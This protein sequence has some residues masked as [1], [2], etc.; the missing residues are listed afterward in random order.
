VSPQGGRTEGVATTGTPPVRAPQAGG[1]S[2]ARHVTAPVSVTIFENGAGQLDVGPGGSRTVYDIHRDGGTWRAEHLQGPE[3]GYTSY[4]ADTV[5]NL[6]RKLA[7]AHGVSGT[8]SIEDERDKGKS[9]TQRFEHQNPIARR[10]QLTDEIRAGG[11][12]GA[13]QSSLSRTL[14]GKLAGVQTPPR[15]PEADAERLRFNT[16]PGEGMR[17][18]LAAQ[19]AASDANVAAVTIWDPETRKP[20]R[21]EQRP[22]KVTGLDRIKN[23]DHRRIAEQA[24]RAGQASYPAEYRAPNIEFTTDGVETMGA[25]W[26]QFGVRVGK[27]AV[28]IHP[29][30]V[31]HR[32]DRMP[33]MVRHELAHRAESILYSKVEAR[34]G[35]AAADAWKAD[36]DREALAWL[37][38]AREAAPDDSRLTYAR[39]TEDFH[40]KG[41][42]GGGIPEH[43]AFAEVVAYLKDG[44]ALPGDSSRLEAL[45]RRADPNFVG[46]SS[47]TGSAS[48]SG[49][50][51]PFNP[52]VA[53]GGGMVPRRDG[54][55]DTAYSLRT[56]PSDDAAKRL[57]EG[58]NA[59][60][61]RA[62]ARDNG[63]TVLS[64]ATKRDLVDK[65]FY[66]LRKALQ[67]SQ[68]IRRL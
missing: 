61:L 27:D 14:Q 24:I 7:D 64:S 53:N 44:Q 46:Q 23:A 58:Y 3:A 4:S 49:L 47:S 36:V 22:V 40:G 17:R 51:T 38:R 37:K 29:N 8:V 25:H 9:L 63:I 13:G 26:D 1:D 39:L 62:I 59:A 56:A 60:G 55:T 32:A 42:R 31:E 35:K 15:N 28:R 41:I 30:Y 33:H 45:L 20:V 65:L 67:N 54:E 21:V 16:T 52:R 43:E 5:A 6:S 68:A 18:A 66:A 19:R 10:L 57:L 12:A 34:D 48:S 11:N 2:I 50:T